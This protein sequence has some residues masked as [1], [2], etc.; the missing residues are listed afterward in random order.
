ME[1]DGSNPKKLT[2]RAA[3]SPHVSPDGKWVVYSHPN[4][5]VLKI[6][7]DGGDE[8]QL[9]DKPAGGGSHL[10]GRQADRL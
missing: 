10:P 2:N 9:T 7:I 3:R 8:V 1:I 5:I 4:N 6:P